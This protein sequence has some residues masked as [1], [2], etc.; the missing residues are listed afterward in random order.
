MVRSPSAVRR[1]TW[2]GW[3]PEPERTSRP[4]DG[5]LALRGQTYDRTDLC[6]IDEVLRVNLGQGLGRQLADQ[7]THRTG[8]G[9]PGINPAAKRRHHGWD[10]GGGL[11]VPCDLVHAHPPRGKA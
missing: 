7:E 1:T 2:L 6:K 8:R 5:P 3:L 9:L 10:I 4:A 11:A